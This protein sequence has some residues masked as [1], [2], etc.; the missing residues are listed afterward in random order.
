M[1]I[2]IPREV[3]SFLGKEGGQ[4]LLIK[5]SAGSGKT[6]LS[7]SLIQA[8]EK[9]G[10]YLSTRVRPSDIYRDCPWIKDQLSSNN[11][12][13]ATNPLKEKI[14]TRERDFSEV[15][16]YGS[17]EDFLVA[18]YERV[19]Q[20][21]R[22]MIIIDSWDSVL[23]QL[24][25]HKEVMEKSLIELCKETRTNLILVGEN[26]DETRLD[27]LMDGVVK[28]EQIR[29]DDRSL[30]IIHLTK[31]RGVQIHQPQYLFTL[32]KGMFR[33]FN[34]FEVNPISNPQK[35]TPLPD[36]NHHFST[37]CKDLD[38]ILKGGFRK[39][40]LNLFEEQLDVSRS[41]EGYVWRCCL[42][43]FIVN[44][45]GVVLVAGEGV[46]PKKIKELSVP[47]VGEELWDTYVR[48]GV[49]G[50]ESSTEPYVVP[51]KG[52]SA[53]RYAIWQKVITELKEATGQPV[54]DYTALDTLEFRSGIENTI[55]KMGDAV[56]ELKDSGDLQ[57][58]L[59][60]PGLEV[61]RQI[62]NLAETYIRFQS[63]FGTAVLYGVH[64]ETGFYVI[65][66]DTSQGYP[67]VTLYPIV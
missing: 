61:S 60:K 19:S 62:I 31:L 46:S 9:N 53:E 12:V 6:I 64:P 11:I 59:A 58:A 18:L 42:F 3:L 7:L 44:H 57:I 1:M 26:P 21:D 48:I 5:G 39:G 10:I 34:R 45:R 8:C 52:N 2:A 16:K 54:Q 15:I 36:T 4:T 40:S 43:N 55:K 65:E 25:T 23:S 66:V 56:R 63:F 41:A 28:L 30:R 37:G 49:Y 33:S 50:I 51:V 24:H 35:W 17:K 20:I 32:H 14:P 29:K 27:Y 47:Y 38:A 22:P 13:D 67:Q